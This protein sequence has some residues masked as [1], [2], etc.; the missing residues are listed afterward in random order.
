MIPEA[1]TQQ[2]REMIEQ[3]KFKEL[4]EFTETDPGFVSGALNAALKRASGGFAA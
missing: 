4:L 1:T 3:R 2:I